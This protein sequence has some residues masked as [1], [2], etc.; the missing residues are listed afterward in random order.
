LKQILELEY[1]LNLEETIQKV[2]TMI[3]VEKLP[4]FN[5]L[6]ININNNSV[7]KTEMK[8]DDNL[9]GNQVGNS[10]IDNSIS[11]FLE[12]VDEEDD[13]NEGEQE[14]ERDYI[15]GKERNNESDFVNRNHAFQAA[16]GY[17]N[18]ENDQDIVG[19][20]DATDF[21]DDIIDVD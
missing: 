2:E 16:L 7:K 19:L 8:I 10:F 14:E 17:G 5:K 3:N 20:S 12:E 6:D 15:G 4:D 1:D 18:D 9:D 21:L 13:E 11:N